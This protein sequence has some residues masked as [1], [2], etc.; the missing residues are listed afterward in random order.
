MTDV[1]TITFFEKHNKDLLPLELSVHTFQYKKLRSKSIFIN[2]DSLSDRCCVLRDSSICI[3]HN[4]VQ[5]GN[6][7]YLIIKKFEI[8]EDFYDVGIPSLLI[9]M[10]KCSL[11]NNNFSVVLIHE[12]KAKCYLMPCWTVNDGESSDCSIIENNEPIA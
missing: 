7:H 1:D 10:F 5:V 3:I 4:I 12:V 8:V 6:S 2:V 9:G 11:L